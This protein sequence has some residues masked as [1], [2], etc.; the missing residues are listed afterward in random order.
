MAKIMNTV[1]IESALVFLETT[2]PNHCQRIALPER[3]YE[4]RSV[5]ALRIGP[6]VSP[7]IPSVL[8]IGGVHAREW[9]GPDIVIN[10]ATDLLRAS[11]ARKGL[12][13]GHKR[14]TANDIRDIS[15][16]VT[17]VVLPCVNPGGVEFSHTK[18]HYWRK[19]RNPASSKPGKPNTIGVDINR[20]YDF[21][22]DYKRYF[23]P[24]ATADTSLASDNPAE[25]TFHGPS[26]FSESETRNVRWL[27]DQLPR[28]V[29]FLDLHSYA[30]DVLYSWGDD[31]DQTTDP[32][33]AFTNR[34]FDGLRGAI[35]DA[36]REYMRPADLQM[37][38]G[39]AQT[40]ADAMRAVR[41][42]PYRPLQ[43][44]GLYPTCGTSDDYC[45]A[46]HIVNT[47]LSKT[48]SYTL[49]FNFASADK[50]FLATS[51][52]KVLAAT[53]RDVVPG[54]LSLCLSAPA[55]AVASFRTHSLDV[56][57]SVPS[58]DSHRT[59]FANDVMRLLGAWEAVAAVRG[60][61]GQSTRRGILA[62]IRQATKGQMH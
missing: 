22:W 21:L 24:A 29:L 32:N 40:V 60:S 16:Q 23:H 50:T 14:F 48:Y 10:F 62:G 38:V 61:A 51:D 53:I 45:F 25:E 33:Q 52:P 39:I 17:V 54:L 28:L 3:T 4:G 7:A 15:D 56:S 20:T 37:A 59:R 9:G 5:H 19:N 49:E 18:S 11:K 44:V 26:A 47:R 13:Y 27:M 34:S 12:T 8:I 55:A 6:E 2:Y 35:G 30:G 57:G 41:G 1:E 36:Y 43:S 58:P 31:Q 46:R 42:Q